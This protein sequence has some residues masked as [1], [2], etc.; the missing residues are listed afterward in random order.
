MGKSWVRCKEVSRRIIEEAFH[1]GDVERS[2]GIVVQKINDRF[3]V[4]AAKFH[5]T[6]IEHVVAPWLQ[7]VGDIFPKFN[8]LGG[9]LGQ[10]MKRWFAEW[11]NNNSE[12]YRN[13]E[14]HQD[15]AR[16]LEEKVVRTVTMCRAMLHKD[17]M[18]M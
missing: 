12:S 9:H 4:N 16:R 5:L 18:V 10:N 11:E 13:S 15:E 7:A 14:A 3:R 6:Y 1:N 2:N 8:E 17:E